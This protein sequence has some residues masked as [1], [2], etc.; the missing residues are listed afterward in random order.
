MESTADTFTCAASCSRYG[1]ASRG[2]SHARLTRQPYSNSRMPRRYRPSR[3][4]DTISYSRSVF[5][6]P[7]AVLFGSS[8][9]RAI[10]VSD[11]GSP[12]SL[13]SCSSSIALATD[14]TV[15][16]FSKLHPPFLLPL[17]PPVRIFVKKFSVLP[18]RFPKLPHVHLAKCTAD[19][20]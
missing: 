10:S 2:T 17:Y 14:R 19:L 16:L 8:C 4:C 13:S 15:P 1:R 3:P 20:L 5:S 12:R 18:N 9:I 11:S 6:R 7:K